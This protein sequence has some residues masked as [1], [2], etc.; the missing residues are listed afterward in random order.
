MSLRLS[1][2]NDVWQVTGTVVTPDGGRLRVRKSTGYDKH[3]KPY[4]QEA[5]G[6]IL[7]EALSGKMSTKTSA[8]SVGQAV[9]LFCERPSGV[10]AT[11]VGILNR[12]DRAY[13]KMRL[14]ELTVADV[15]LW[16][17]ARG[18]AAST[19]KREINSIMAMLNH[20]RDMGL[21]VPALQLKKPKVDDTRTRWL[22]ESERDAL[23]EAS[24]P[25]IKGLVTFLFF[26]GAR[27]GE[28]F[29][30]SHSDVVDGKAML[31][32]RKGKSGKT[33]V[34]AVPLVPQ[35]RRHIGEGGTGLVF[36][37]TKGVMWDRNN[38]YDY[39]YP[40]CDCVGIKDFR[41]HDCR[42]TFASLLV[43]RGASLR[44]VADL[45]G[46]SSLAM[47]MRYSHLA[48]SHLESTIGLLGVDGTKVTHAK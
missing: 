28:A 15:Q 14:V 36:P 38:F 31:G 40:A 17:N 44:A 7:T 39:F 47:V 45:L 30:L 5:M 26:T 1:L 9:R 42:H 6:R 4:A 41:P 48:P 46:H 13:G 19:V 20:A 25:M 8:V 27:L 16:V 3:M 10:G 18:N 2:R 23:I 37:N 33:R 24:D 35:I 32:T 34:R 29:R 22:T 21:E 12:F 43:Q 11:D